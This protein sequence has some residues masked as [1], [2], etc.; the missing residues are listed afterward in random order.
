MHVDLVVEQWG[1]V[2]VGADVFDVLLLG[3][4]GN[5]PSQLHHFLRV[6]LTHVLLEFWQ[7]FHDIL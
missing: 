5:L 1:D 4:R 6:C 2:L 3:G 7:L